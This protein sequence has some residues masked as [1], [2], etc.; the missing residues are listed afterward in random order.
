MQAITGTASLNARFPGQWFRIESGLHYN[1]HRHYDPTIGRYTQPDPLGF[2]DGPALF[3]YALGNP[4]AIID[5]LGLEGGHHWV[6]PPV[7]NYPG[8]SKPAADVFQSWTTGTL[9]GGHNYS[10]PHPAYNKAVF[11]H[12][13]NY[14]AANNIYPGNMSKS[15]T[16]DFV[17]SVVKSNDPK[18]RSL[19]EQV[20]RQ[21]FSRKRGSD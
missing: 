20:I 18:I 14:C 16:E 17:R 3:A 7:R 15:Q 5:L 1:W 12:F 8:L 21:S 13:E 19:R 11:S 9:P 2:V 6:S 10:S 4:L